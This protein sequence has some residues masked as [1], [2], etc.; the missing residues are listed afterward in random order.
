MLSRVRLQ[1]RFEPL[2]DLEQYEKEEQ[3]ERHHRKRQNIGYVREQA[4]PFGPVP[5]Q[6]LATN[7]WAKAYR[8]ANFSVGGTNIVRVEDAVRYEAYRSWR[9]R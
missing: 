8:F 4:I 7:E 5:P 6:A 9:E 3:A 1:P 2:V